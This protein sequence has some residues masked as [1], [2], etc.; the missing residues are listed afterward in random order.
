MA[1]HILPRKYSVRMIDT[2]KL[3][4]AMAP[5]I[6]PRKYSVRMIDTQKLKI[7]ISE[8]T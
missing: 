8:L 1:T 2:Q 6:L 5:H 3:K 7:C 4:I